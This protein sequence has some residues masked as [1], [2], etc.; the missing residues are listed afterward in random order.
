MTQPSQSPAK[1]RILP[2]SCSVLLLV[3]G[4]VLMSANG[5]VSQVA[6]LHRFW[7]SSA[8]MGGGFVLSWRLRSLPTVWFWGVAIATRLLLLP[9]AP[10]DDVWRYLW[11][12][13]IQT[14]GFSP[15]SLAPNAPE[16]AF[17]RTD[18][19][20]LINFPEVSAIYPP[21]TQ[22]GF[23]LLAT[24]SPNLYLFK[25]AFIL[26]DLLVCWL[27][28]RRFG[29]APSTL[30]A[31][32]PMIIYAFAGGAHY[33]SW[34]I[35]PLVVAWLGAE[36]KDSSPRPLSW[37]WSALWIGVSMAVKWV[38]LP[39][40]AF[41]MG[42][43]LR[44]RKFGQMIG[45]GLAGLLPMVLFALPFCSLKNCPLIP[46]ESVFVAYGRSAEFLPH[47]LALVWP[48]SL[49][50]NWIFGVPLALYVLW[51]G[52][53]T[54]RFQ[55]FAEAYWFGLLLLTP[56]VHFWYFTWMVPF[57]VPSQNWGAR[58]VSLSAFVYF[59]LP[60]RV[61]DWRL[62]EWERL[63]LWLP[64]VAGWLWSAWQMTR[65]QPQEARSELDTR[66]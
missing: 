22:F 61:P 55:Q 27:L 46:T 54:R 38:S 65:D 5:N 45:A 34:F 35:L 19:W 31:W 1:D 26:P 53:Q 10:G 36:G 3:G 11:E 17:L 43:S 18:W 64:F 32:N 48:P 7:V 29:N 37:L 66:L 21:L 60:S 8:I 30:Y 15:Y 13:L 56:I 28:S 50:A 51:L 39:L 33:D 2:L 40:M 14:H 59:V 24:L 47:F 25:L 63:F 41:L 9:M 58:W 20:S 62:T 4:A 23:R 12:G 49:K 6:T 42:R 57:T 16:L 52:W 44:Q